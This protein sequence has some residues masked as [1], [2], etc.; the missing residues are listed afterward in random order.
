MAFAF[1]DSYLKL[2]PITKETSV[3]G[4]GENSKRGSSSLVRDNH[5]LV[6]LPPIVRL[7]SVRSSP[8]SAQSFSARSET[9]DDYECEMTT[10]IGSSVNISHKMDILGQG[11]SKKIRK[12]VGK[13]ED[14]CRL[15][16]EP[17]VK[18]TS[19]AER[20]FFDS[21]HRTT[22]EV[23]MEHFRSKERL[24]GFQDDEE[25][26]L[27]CR[28]SGVNRAG[29]AKFKNSQKLSRSRRLAKSSPELCHRKINLKQSA[30][31]LNVRENKDTSLTPPGLSPE[32]FPLASKAPRLSVHDIDGSVV[33]HL[34]KVVKNEG[35]TKRENRGRSQKAGSIRQPPLSTP[36]SPVCS[37]S[38]NHTE[39]KQKG[40][41]SLND[42]TETVKQII[43]RR[44][45]SIS[46]PK[47]QNLIDDA[48]GLKIEGRSCPQSEKEGLRTSTGVSHETDSLLPP[49][50]DEKRHSL[51][52]LQQILSLL[53]CEVPS[54]KASPSDS[55]SAPLTVGDSD[56]SANASVYDL[57][58]FLMLAATAEASS[59][60]QL[61]NTAANK[62]RAGYEAQGASSAKLLSPN[63]GRERVHDSV[64]KGSVYDLM[65]FLSLGNASH[66]SSAST[67][68]NSSRS[69]SPRVLISPRGVGTSESLS[70]SENSAHETRR[71]STYDLMEFLSLSRSGANSRPESGQSSASSQGDNLVDSANQ[72]NSDS[73]GGKNG[74]ESR[75][76]SVYDLAEF[77][78][79]TNDVPPLVRVNAASSEDDIIASNSQGNEQ[80]ESERNS[81]DSRSLSVYDLA[82]FLSMTSDVPPLVRVTTS[83]E[84]LLTTNPGTDLKQGESE[85][86]DIYKEDSLSDLREIHNAMQQEPHT[87][88]T[89]DAKKEPLP[90]PS[91]PKTASS[92]YASDSPLSTTDSN[93]L[94]GNDNTNTRHM[95]VYDL[96]EF[97]SLCATQQSTP[98]QQIPTWFTRKFS[99]ASQSGISIHV[100]DANN[101]SLDLETD[102]V[103][104]PVPGGE[105][106][107]SES[108][109]R[110]S[111]YDLR[112]FLNILN[113]DDSPLRRRLSSV[114]SS[115][116]KSSESESDFNPSSPKSD[117]NSAGPGFGVSNG[118]TAQ[119]RPQLSPRQDS[120][121]NVSLY[122]L[123]EFL[124]LLNTDDSP[125]RR[126]LSST[127][128]VRSPKSDTESLKSPLYSLEEIL[129]VLNEFEQKKVNEN[130]DGD[131]KTGNGDEISIPVPSLPTRNERTNAQTFPP[132][133]RFP[134]EKSFNTVPET[135]DV[136]ARLSL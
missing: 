111:V 127:G 39:H 51:Y 106:N 68:E 116:S 103:F 82:E 88:N 94:Q 77:L 87:V 62:L 5:G 124:S 61:K 34:Q 15:I 41:K 78:S 12:Y 43:D 50:K 126:R 122:D 37:E 46:A 110:S 53:Q 67:S 71:S 36:N 24:R 102:E 134:T 66:P 79:M 56:K 108:R 33:F 10:R 85:R 84:E 19:K 6:R 23:N 114:S 112:E 93:S 54:G 109:K 25:T 125:L 92:G 97:L 21:E 80:S 76:L 11:S 98:S 38:A 121:G 52:D 20:R 30:G 74:K 120:G 8:S 100:T 60:R 115:S 136:K 59:G 135:S 128:D 3:E 72:R 73:E 18:E 118:G 2:P 7:D 63:Q 130:T 83:N 81:R 45:P 132:R 96:R 57:R 55:S 113:A 1:G 101:R 16:N 70:V 26:M 13:R 65:E 27:L 99:S 89:L 119:S 64:R 133:K 131:S 86:R 47:K 117:T 44:K 95:S 4:D 28:D 75:S 17:A 107:S 40:R 9:T 32:S 123:G 69:A 35:K 58:E 90:S 104:L 42:I 14:E 29:S 31:A 129:T 49:Q 48:S 22:E 105:T 91:P